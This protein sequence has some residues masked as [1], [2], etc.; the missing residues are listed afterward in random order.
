LPPLNILKRKRE[1]P[2]GLVRRASHDTGDDFLGRLTSAD[3]LQ[4][5]LARGL[6]GFFGKDR[7]CGLVTSCRI[8]HAARQS[9]GFGSCRC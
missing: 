8:P 5:S 9:G 2:E 4:E 1:G 3:S 6:V 7:V